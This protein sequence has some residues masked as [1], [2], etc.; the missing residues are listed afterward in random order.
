MLRLTGYI[1]THTHAHTHTQGR[2]S[3]GVLG[4]NPP[5]LASRSVL[6]VNFFS[7]AIKI[8]CTIQTHTHAR[9]RAYCMSTFLTNAVLQFKITNTIPKNKF[10]MFG[11]DVMT[12][13]VSKKEEKFKAAKACQTRNGDLERFFE[14][15]NQPFPPSLSEYGTLH[16]ARQVWSTQIQ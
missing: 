2:L 4:F 6:G 10:S 3:F 11:K 9:T 16:P 5:T 7:L 13:D 15:E 1:H 12:K 14:H 8:G